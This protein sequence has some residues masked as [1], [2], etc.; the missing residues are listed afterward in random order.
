M[1]LEHHHEAIVQYKPISVK[2][3]CEDGVIRSPDAVAQDDDPEVR[4]GNAG[5]LQSNILCEAGNQ[6]F[7]F[8]E[9]SV[10][11]PEA[12]RSRQFLQIVRGNVKL[13]TR[14]R[15][16]YCS[17]E[18][19]FVQRNQLKTSISRNTSAEHLARPPSVFSIDGNHVTPQNAHFAGG[20]MNAQAE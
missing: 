14:S 10:G 6:I 1:V 15:R 3:G 19:R 17:L 8:D 9:L 12:A 4:S 13:S 2:P 16:R 20:S 7:V 11:R 5:F 18:R